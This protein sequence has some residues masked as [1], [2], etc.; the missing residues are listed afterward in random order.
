MVVT[1]LL[2]TYNGTRFLREQ[3]ES[4]LS[5]ENVILQIFVRDDG[6]SDN[7]SQMLDEYQNRGVLE[8]YTGPNLRPAKS[9]L[10]LLFWA[11]DS[12]YYAFCDQDDVWMPDKLKTA[13][14]YI[15]NHEEPA[16]YCSDTLLVD[17]TLQPIRKAGIKA[18]CTFAESLIANSVTGCTVVINKALREIV[19]RYRPNVIDMHD[20]WVYRVCMAIGGYFYFDTTPHILYRQ[21]E[22]NVIGGTGTKWHKYKRQIGYFLHPK[23]GIRYTMAKELHQGFYDIMPDDKRALLERIV[24]YKISFMYTLRLAFDKRFKLKNNTVNKDFFFAVLLRKY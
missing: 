24:N 16:M 9:F 14:E 6:S 22:N 8:W 19:C 10:D 13:I 5:Q 15:K 2:S 4:V 23:E 3:I 17:V 20:W 18:E 7:T 21:H 12:D 1:I 11:P